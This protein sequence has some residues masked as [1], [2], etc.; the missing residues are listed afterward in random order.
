[1]LISPLNPQLA[2][3]TSPIS[4]LPYSW[5]LSVYIL[6][7]ANLGSEAEKIGILVLAR[8]VTNDGARVL[9]VE[10]TMEIIINKDDRD[11]YFRSLLFK[12]IYIYISLVIDA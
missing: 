3:F 7:K 12:Y 5:N 4:S 9:G 1:M 11:G 6:L 8:A 2:L 10:G